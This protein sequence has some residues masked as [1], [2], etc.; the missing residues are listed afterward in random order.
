MLDAAGRIYV[1]FDAQFSGADYDF[2]IARVRG[3][4]LFSD[5]F[6]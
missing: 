6:E 3:N 1:G 4:V 5:G 2:A